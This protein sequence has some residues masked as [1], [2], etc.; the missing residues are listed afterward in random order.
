MV[1]MRKLVILG[2]LVL[3]LLVSGCSK[4]PAEA[5]I[6]AAET[7]VEQVRPD[8]EKFVPAMF[9]PLAEALTAAK[10]KFDEGDY[11]AALAGAKDLP[12]KAQ[13]VSKAALAKKDEVT[14]QWTEL[15]GSLPGVVTSLTDKIGALEA[16]KKLPKEFGAEQLATAKMSLD[17]VKGMW[18][19]AS[20]A[21]SSGDIMGAVAKAGDV[22]TKADELM[23]MLEAVPMPA[24]K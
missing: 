20:D 12:A 24:A 19:T 9:A 13:E 22:K 15:S 5:A 6:K 16:M 8:A 4:G 11:A 23:K 7:A 14:A 17:E 18:T 10:A 2:L 21:F 3:P 1:I